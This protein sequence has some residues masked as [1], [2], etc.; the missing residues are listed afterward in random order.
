MRLKTIINLLELIRKEVKEEETELE[1]YGSSNV[2]R[3]FITNEGEDI[4]ASGGGGE[5]G[6]LAET[7]SRV[8]GN[9]KEI[10]GRMVLRIGDS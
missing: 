5:Q 1:V 2:V 9:E 10:G 8:L 3:R 7:V 6:D 4:A